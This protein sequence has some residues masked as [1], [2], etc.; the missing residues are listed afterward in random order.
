MVVLALAANASPAQNAV[1]VLRDVLSQ[2]FLIVP[3]G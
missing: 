2:S 3:S 1:Q